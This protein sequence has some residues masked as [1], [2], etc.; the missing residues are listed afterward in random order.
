MEWFK[1]IV[2]EEIYGELETNGSLEKIKGKF[3]DS[4]YIPHDKDKWIE[5]HVFNS[6]RSEMKALKDKIVGYES[7]LEKRKDFI[8]DDEHKTKLADSEATFQNRLK[9]IEDNFKLELSKKE[10]ENLLLNLY[11]S[12]GC[13]KPKYLLNNTNLDDVIVKD[14][15][16]QNAKD[17]VDGFK[18]DV[19]E[20]FGTNLNPNVPNKGQGGSK[21][22]KE[23][24]I[25]Q[26]NK[27]PSGA[28][29]MALQRQIQNLNK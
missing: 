4:E 11:T 9:E 8:T 6:Q 15:S 23:Q 10:K 13:R 14:G 16:I 2:G 18:S 7:E 22:T 28:Q 29:K 3:G 27:M 5:K 20:L 24:L 25:E 19:P 26:Y 12:S 17:L 1:S 21:T